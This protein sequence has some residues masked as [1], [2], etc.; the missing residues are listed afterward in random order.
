M[1]VE[2]EPGALLGEQRHFLAKSF[3]DTFGLASKLL[4]HTR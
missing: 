3:L 2:H 1:I 4:T